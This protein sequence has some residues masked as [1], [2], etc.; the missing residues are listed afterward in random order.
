MAAH[1]AQTGKCEGFNLGRKSAPLLLFKVLGWSQTRRFSR[2][3]VLV[4]CGAGVR[5]KKRVPGRFSILVCQ[6]WGPARWPLGH[7]GTDCIGRV[8]W[9]ARWV[10]SGPRGVGCRAES[11]FGDMCADM[12]SGDRFR[13]FIESVQNGV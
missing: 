12:G 5:K 2:K 7:L 6:G 9:Q 10:R 3:G 4:R 13:L 1:V 11:D 8:C